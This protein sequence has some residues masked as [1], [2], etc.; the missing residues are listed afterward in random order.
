MDQEL[1]DDKIF[2]FSPENFDFP[3]LR[4]E[5]DSPAHLRVTRP[6]LPKSSAAQNSLQAVEYTFLLDMLSP[7]HPAHQFDHQYMKTLEL[8]QN[9]CY[10][11]MRMCG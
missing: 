3:G 9:Y 4:I 6:L 2:S 7:L 1:T 5:F 10:P 8:R 11:G